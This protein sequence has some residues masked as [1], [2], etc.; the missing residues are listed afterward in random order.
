VGAAIA[1][2][3]WASVY[4]EDSLGMFALAF[5][6]VILL[7]SE[8]LP[9]TMGVVYSRTLAPPLARPMLWMVVFFKPVARLATLMGRLIRRNNTAPDASEEDIL[10]LVSMTRRAGVIK[11]YEARSIHNI[12]SLDDKTVAEIMTPRTVVFS[13]PEGMTVAQARD[14]RSNWP[15]SRFPVYEGD[16][17]EDVVGV[18][19]RRQVF[20]AL[21]DDEDDKRLSDLMRPVR[22]VPESMT[23]DKVLVRFLESR[24][25]L[26]VVLDEY[27]G[28]AGVEEILGSEIVDETDQVVD[29][30][31]LARRRR[32]AV[33]SRRAKESRA[34]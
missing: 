12:L 22:F 14:S 2:A 23:L 20:E 15:H 34:G 8:I 7:L 10:A 33:A 16:D 13:L 25:H 30:R 32:D 21:A 29:M 11:P 28:I 9:K 27:G 17:P 18:V 26:F 24:M 3:A 19:Y 4:G 1:G 5:T 6:V 31:D